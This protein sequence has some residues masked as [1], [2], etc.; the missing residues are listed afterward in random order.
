M[1]GTC[2]HPVSQ[3]CRQLTLV[4]L[5]SETYLYVTGHSWLL[6]LHDEQVALLAV[7]RTVD[8]RDREGLLLGVLADTHH[9]E[10]FRR[11]QQAPFVLLA[12]APHQNHIQGHVD[13]WSAQRLKHF[14]VSEEKNEAKASLEKMVTY[15]GSLFVPR[16]RPSPI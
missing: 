10:H 3:L 9:E 14:P 16:Q 2:G 13:F 8:L 15:Q 5:F 11:Q 1:P 7:L 4:T 12:R 6:K